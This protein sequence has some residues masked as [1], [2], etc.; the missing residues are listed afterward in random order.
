MNKSHGVEK[1][2]LESSEK[3]KTGISNIL[4]KSITKLIVYGLYVSLFLSFLISLLFLRISSDNY[5]GGYI[6][7]RLHTNIA[8]TRSISTS[9]T[10][11]NSEVQVHICNL[12]CIS[13]VSRFGLYDFLYPLNFS[14]FCLI[15][16]KFCF[17]FFV[18]YFIHQ[19]EQL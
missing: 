11:I 2:K 14:E 3:T 7:Q 15:C 9:L 5:P 16:L 19:S 18:L 6:F 4:L 10:H 1:S 13:G 17:F 12:A 8:A